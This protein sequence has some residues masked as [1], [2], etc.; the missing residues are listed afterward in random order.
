M[1]SALIGAGL[2]D[3]PA[4]L[5]G[6]AGTSAASA[7]AS[8]PARGPPAA[9]MRARARALKETAPE[10]AVENAVDNGKTATTESTADA[11]ANTLSS[12]ARTHT[13]QA[14]EAITPEGAQLCGERARHAAVVG[15]TAGAPLPRGRHARQV[16]GIGRMARH[17]ERCSHLEPQ[18]LAQHRGVAA[19]PIDGGGSQP[20][21]GVQPAAASARQHLDQSRRD[22][23]QISVRQ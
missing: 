15:C 13:H 9:A 14:H 3:A 22:V 7:A 5:P 12:A 21:R 23:G 4:E 6:R 2:R 1:R 20:A 10:N 8:R 18:H 17:R 19:L 16:L 11:T